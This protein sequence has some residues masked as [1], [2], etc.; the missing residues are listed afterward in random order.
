MT[1]SVLGATGK[2]GRRVVERLRADGAQVRAA[3][4]SGEVRFDW[5]EP[6]GWGAVLDGARAVYLVAPEDPAPI[7]PFV[8]RAVAAGV[9][10]F[11]VLSGRGLEHTTQFG[12]GMA[13]AED[14]VRGSGAEW[15]I[16]RANNFDQNFDE[17]LWHAPLLAGRLAL[18][19][20]AIGEPFI[21]VADIAEVAAAL[22]TRDGHDGK[23]YELSGPRA[24][25]FAQAAAAIA[26]CSGRTITY[27]ELTPDEYRDELLAEGWPQEG[28]HELNAL[29]A[30]LRAGHTSAPT[31][32]V[33]HLLGRPATDF[34]TYVD[35]VWSAPVGAAGPR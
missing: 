18:P 24:L 25:T 4:R 29:F 12:R 9:R 33:R 19:I 6:A 28:A 11:V 23:V 16:M 7:P 22:L 2:T 13:V 20:G 27:Q 32:T 26:A 5:A 34:E 30:L 14:T 15:T 31:D 21:D 35:R 1:I 8:A 3:S 17:D 10:R